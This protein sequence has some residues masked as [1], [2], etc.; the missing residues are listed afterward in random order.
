MHVLAI[1]I[2]HISIVLVYREININHASQHQSISCLHTYS[3][4]WHHNTSYLRYNDYIRHAYILVMST[5][6]HEAHITQVWVCEVAFLSHSST[7]VH[8]AWNNVHTRVYTH[9]YTRHETM[10]IRACIHMYTRHGT[11]CIRARCFFLLYTL[12]VGRDSSSSYCHS[13]LHSHHYTRACK[14]T[15]MYVYTHCFVVCM[16]VLASFF[17][18]IADHVT[19]SQSRTW[20]VVM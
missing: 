12:W 9:M 14:Y 16:T 4:S 3:A 2:A 10:C 8:K 20:K 7:Y 6:V 18:L 11:M 5:A 1:I 17:I 15:S 13:F 19:Y